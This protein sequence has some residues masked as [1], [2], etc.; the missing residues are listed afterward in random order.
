MHAAVPPNI[1]I[2]QL[3]CRV[4]DDGAIVRVHDGVR[5]SE[6]PDV[7][8]VKNMPIE[9]IKKF[10]KFAISQTKAIYAKHRHRRY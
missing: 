1:Q 10:I 7:Q 9:M 6:A 8:V 5:G 4:D 2:G 3:I